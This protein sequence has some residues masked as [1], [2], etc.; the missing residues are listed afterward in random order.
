MADIPMYEWKRRYPN[1]DIEKIHYCV[2]KMTDSDKVQYVYHETPIVTIEGNTITLTSGGW[3]TA[4]TKKNINEVLGTENLP[5]GVYQ[6]NSVWYITKG[7]RYDK[8]DQ[9]P[10]ADGMQVTRTGFV[11]EVD[12]SEVDRIKSI[13]KLVK[14]YCK[15][16]AE[17]ETL[18]EPNSG[19]CWVCSM[20]KGADCLIDHLEEQ[21]IHGSLIIRALEERGYADPAFIWHCGN[22]DMIVRAVRRYFYRHL[23]IA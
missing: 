21:Y 19:D 15:A 17:L 11:G 16:I 7:Q 2:A 6:E 4:T 23:G 22:R 18:P 13:K 20:F 5:F 14:K 1:S 12:T 8:T 3:R 9:R 10:F